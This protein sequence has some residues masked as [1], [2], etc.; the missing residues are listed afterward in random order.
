MKSWVSMAAG[1][2]LGCALEHA[3]DM[4]FFADHIGMS[5]IQ[6][7]SRKIMVKGSGFP[8]LGRMTGTAILTKFSGM[9]VI[10]LVARKTSRR[11]TLKQLINM[12]IRAFCFGVFAIQ[13]ENRK[14][15][16]KGS[17]FP[18]SGL[19]TVATGCPKLAVMRVIFEMANTAISR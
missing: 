4:A 2:F 12:A 6:F 15:V 17:R 19:M 7:E 18:G 3:I 8:G 13:F 11:G 5:A 16:V 9:L 10:F 1:T 14:I